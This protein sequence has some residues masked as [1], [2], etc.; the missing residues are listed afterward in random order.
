MAHKLFAIA[1]LFFFMFGP[2]QVSAQLK[3]I[4]LAVGSI[5]LAEIPFNLA[6]LKGFYREEG[7]DVDIILIRGSARRA[8]PC[9]RLRGLFFV[10]GIGGRCGSARSGG[11]TSYGTFL[12][13]AV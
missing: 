3:K 12:E 11:K 8:G 10:V 7:L 1:S 5:S 4:T 9:R 2:T 6:K 13:A